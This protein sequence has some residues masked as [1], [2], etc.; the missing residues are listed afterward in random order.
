MNEFLHDKFVRIE[1]H[2][3][4]SNSNSHESNSNRFFVISKIR[5]RRI[6]Y[7]NTPATDVHYERDSAVLW[8]SALLVRLQQTMSSLKRVLQIIPTTSPKMLSSVFL[9]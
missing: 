5:I 4:N 8:S 2:N 7:S 6:E 1:S 3:V 9:G